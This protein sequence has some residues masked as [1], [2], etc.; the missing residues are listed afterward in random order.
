MRH[1]GWHGMAQYL[2][3]AADLLSTVGW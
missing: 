2:R 3:E 1:S